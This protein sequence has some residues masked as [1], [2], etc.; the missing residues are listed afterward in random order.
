L[1]GERKH[2]RLEPRHDFLE[3]GLGAFEL[4]ARYDMLRFNDATF[5]GTDFGFPAASKL[6]ANSDRAATAGLNWYLNRY[7]KVQGN[8]ILEMIADP[9]RSPAP[10][11]NGRF[12]SAM[13]R[14]QFRL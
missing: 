9:A 5:P 6:A 7:V 3:G 2:G 10:S 12:T 11:T 4:V 13:L 14:V 8:V 1:T